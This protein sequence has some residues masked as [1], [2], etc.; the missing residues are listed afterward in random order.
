M[1]HRRR[2]IDNLY[3]AAPLDYFAG[4]GIVR[5]RTPAKPPR[6]VQL[7]VQSPCRDQ[8]ELAESLEITGQRGG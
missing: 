1:C 8:H 4:G 5:P 3:T 2:D 6:V 7:V